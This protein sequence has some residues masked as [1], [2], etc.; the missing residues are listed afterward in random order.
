M[1]GPVL[2][3]P[4]R[5]AAE[6]FL[7]G[8]GRHVIWMADSPAL[9]LPRIVCMLAN[10]AAFAVGEGVASETTIDL[11]LRL[12]VNYPKGPL[13]WA[14]ELGYERVVA[15]LDHL[16]AEYHEERYRVAPLLRRLARLERL[17]D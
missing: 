3:A 1:A 8:L 11:A 14:K 15:V 7:S 9:V 6:R 5:L 10:E 4:A 12:G 2:A 16:Y 17:G 13:A